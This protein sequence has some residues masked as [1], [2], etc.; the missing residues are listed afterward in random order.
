MVARACARIY[1]LSYP[2]TLRSPHGTLGS[3]YCGTPAS[4]ILPSS[5]VLTRA[6]FVWHTQ[7]RYER[8]LAGCTAQ[9]TAAEEQSRSWQAELVRGQERLDQFR[10]VMN[11]NLEELS[12]WVEASRQKEEDFAALGQYTRK[13]DKLTRD[14]QLQLER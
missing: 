6:P 10:A 13:D 12:Q 8:E 9:R 3:S 14:L 1:N 4:D 2:G 11:W 5:G 7:E